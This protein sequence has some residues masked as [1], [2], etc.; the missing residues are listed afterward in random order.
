MSMEPLPFTPLVII[1]AGR[2]GTN[3]LRDTL[4]AL[5]GFE[6]WPCDEIN[7]IWRHGNIFWPDDE[8]PV[9]R[10]TP[11]IR[12]FIRNQFIKFWKSSGK[13]QYVVEKTCA[14]TLRIPFVDAVLPEARYIDLVRNG[15]DV[16]ASAQKRWQGDFELPKGSYFMAK[17]RYTPLRDLPIYGYRFLDARLKMALGEA[18]HLGIWGP[19]FKGMSEMTDTALIDLCALQWAVCLERSGEAF[20]SMTDSKVAEITYEDFM[21]TPAA[22]IRRVLDEVAPSE[23]K[24]SD[25]AI[26][27]AIGGVRAPSASKRNLVA[28]QLTEAVRD[29]VDA[30][31]R[32]KGYE[33]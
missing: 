16:V 29:R 3:I 30:I 23:P 17:A 21:T 25:A 32:A 2:S 28:P 12:Q 18:E 27:A 15:Y 31:M 8:I 9:E 7:P 22:V 4:T 5:D 14:N 20:G 13:P 26:N 19:R 1:G 6:T 24:V 33:V 10:V 11:A